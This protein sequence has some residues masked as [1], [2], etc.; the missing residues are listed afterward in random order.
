MKGNKSLKEQFTCINANINSKQINNGYTAA[1]LAMPMSN[2]RSDI[3]SICVHQI[4][5]DYVS[6]HTNAKWPPVNHL[7]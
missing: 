2:T 7:K 1:V 3:W 4:C 6:Y 5:K